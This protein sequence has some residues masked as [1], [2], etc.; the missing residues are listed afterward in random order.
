MRS[1]Q[2][3]NDICYTR[4]NSKHVSVCECV[5]VYVLWLLIILNSVYEYNITNIMIM[6]L[7]DWTDSGYKT[8]ILS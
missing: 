7:L 4:D 1:L 2:E 3:Y 8:I 6:A 5:C